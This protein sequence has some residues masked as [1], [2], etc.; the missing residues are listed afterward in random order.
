MAGASRKSVTPAVIPS[1]ADRYFASL[2]TEHGHTAIIGAMGAGKTILSFDLA[3][4][5]SDPPQP[6]TQE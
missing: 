1:D 6:F 3:R 4:L 2:N 5:A